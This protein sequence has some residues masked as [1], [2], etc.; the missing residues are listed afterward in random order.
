MV[1]VKIIMYKNIYTIGV[2]SI[3]IFIRVHKIN[4][5]IYTTYMTYK[6]GGGNLTQNFLSS[7]REGDLN[8]PPLEIWFSCKTY[9][10]KQTV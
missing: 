10:F 3:Y 8:G 4:I 6:L 1:T 7:A 5:Y 2:Y 9:L